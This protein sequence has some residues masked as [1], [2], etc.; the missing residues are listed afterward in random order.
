MGNIFKNDFK[1]SD[2]VSSPWTWQLKV[3]GTFRNI[4]HP[5]SDFIEA[6]YQQYLSNPSI[7]M[8]KIEDEPYLDFRSM[9]LNSSLKMQRIRVDQ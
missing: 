1:S 2:F 9:T 8:L 7:Y 5:I 6:Y 3:N 4:H